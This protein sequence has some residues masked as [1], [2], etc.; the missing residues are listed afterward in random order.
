MSRTV[1][2]NPAVMN[3]TNLYDSGGFH[4]VDGVHVVLL[5]SCADGQDVGVKYDVIGVKAHLVDEEVIRP[6]TD[7]HLLIDIC[8]L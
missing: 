5:H 4:E 3:V 8:C 2:K 6:G 7:L 1:R